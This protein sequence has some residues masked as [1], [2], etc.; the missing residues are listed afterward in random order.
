MEETGMKKTSLQECLQSASAEKR[1]LSGNRPILLDDPSSAWIIAEGRAEIYAL[2]Q[3]DALTAGMRRHLF[4]AH[5]GELL[6]GFAADT[7][8]MTLIAVGMPGT[9]AFRLDSGRLFDLPALGDTTSDTPCDAAQLP[10]RFL[11]GLFS[12]LPGGWAD[13]EEKF[14]P[15]ELLMQPDPRRALD[16]VVATFLRAI[17]MEWRLSDVDAYDAMQTKR[18]AAARSLDTGLGRLKEVFGAVGDDTPEKSA[19]PLVAACARVVD[20]MG[21]PVEETHLPRCD[22]VGSVADAWGLRYRPVTLRENWWRQDGGAL[23]GFLS[24]GESGSAASDHRPVALLPVGSGR[25]TAHDPSTG[26]SFAIDASSARHMAPGA[27]FFYAP[28]PDKPL[29]F[30]DLLRHA[31]FGTRRD[32]AYLVFCGMVLALLAV[33]PPVAIKIIFSD[34][35]P[36]ADRMLLVQI[37]LLLAVVAASVFVFSIIRTV[38]LVRLAVKIDF[39]LDTASWDRLIR[40]PADIHRGESSGEWSERVEGLRVVRIRLFDSFVVTLLS[41]IFAA[42]NVV[43]LFVFGPNLALPALGLLLVGALVGTWF[44]FRQVESWRDYFALCGRITG[45]LTQ[46]FSGIAKIRLSGSEG[47]VFELWASDF[48]SQQKQMMRANRE[49]N[50]LLVFNMVFPV[51]AMIVLFGLAAGSSGPMIA[52]GSFLAFL[53][54]YVALQ[55]ALLAVTSAA[56]QLSSVFPIYRRMQ[57]IFNTLPENAGR[58][59]D[60]GT[61]EGGIEIARLRF[62]YAPEEPFVLD[63][64]DLTIRP[65]E[66]VAVVGPSGSGKSTLLRLLLGLEKPTSG[67]IYY[68]DKNLADLDLFK[69]RRHHLGTVMQSAALLPGDI[70]SNIIGM[71]NLGEED[72]WEALRQVGFEDDVRR[73]PLGLRTPIGTGQ[74][75]FSGGEKQR[76]AIARAIAGKPSILFLDE[77]TSALDNRTQEIVTRSLDALSMTR[78]VIAHRLSTVRNADRIVLLEAGHIVEAGSYAELMEKKGRFHDLVKRQLLME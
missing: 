31:L 10:A 37:A 4:T 57:A 15:Q 36:G 52:T 63:D 5:A 12:S 27:F 66:F 2:R 60:P 59:N 19:T 64:F 14:L 78:L 68:D 54:A 76:L 72:A 21:I 62:R 45:K 6:P 75:T 47:R 69:L 35:I 61:L 20:A 33:V 48:A 40:L 22:T 28:F 29:D 58:G 74:D 26:R 44:N 42:S 53:S 71:K 24:A 8:G 3:G 34:I 11:T 55:T 32:L 30:L 18:T 9:T 25:Y 7:R 17:E 70:L 13:A 50:A 16:R 77:A 38:T 23:L 73:L 43:M 65:G 56:V 39:R 41:G 49:Q 67:A 51:A 46:F 1:S